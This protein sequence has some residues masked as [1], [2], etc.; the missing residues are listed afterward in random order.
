MTEEKPRSLKQ[1]IC[2]FIEEQWKI[3]LKYEKEGRVRRVDWQAVQKR[4]DGLLDEAAASAPDRDK[5]KDETALKHPELHFAEQIVVAGLSYAGQMERW[6]KEVFDAG[7]GI[8]VSTVQEILKNSKHHHGYVPK[9]EGGDTGAVL[10]KP[11]CKNH[12]WTRIAESSWFC[13]VCGEEKPVLSG[14]YP[15][16]PEE[17]SRRKEDSG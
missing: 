16:E 2:D 7:S 9:G 11:V 14:L 12:S 15:P 10:S 6:K 4:L 8:S 13:S 3:E 17:G 1:L 5:I